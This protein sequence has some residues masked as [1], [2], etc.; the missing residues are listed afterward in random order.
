MRSTQRP[1]KKSGS[2]DSP[3]PTAMRGVSYWPGTKGFAPAIVYGTMDGWLIAL[4]T[5]SGKPVPTFGSGGMVDLKIGEVV[6]PSFK[7]WGVRSPPAI[8][9]NFVIPG[10]FPG[11]DPAFG[12]HADIRAFDMRTGKVTWTFHTLPQPGEANHETWKDGQ[13]ENRAGAE[14]M[15]LHDR[16]RRAEHALRFH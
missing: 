4:D 3:H 5:K 11:E 13:W 14:F 15:G 6:D 10:C 9:K 2:Y 12:A 8:F 16:G 1:E 7:T